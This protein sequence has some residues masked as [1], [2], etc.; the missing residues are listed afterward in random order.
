MKSILPLVLPAFLISIGLVSCEKKSTAPAESSTPETQKNYPDLASQPGQ[1]AI[2]ARCKACHSDIHHHWIK[3][4]H[5]QANRLLDPQ[6]DSLPFSNKSLN[7]GGEQWKFTTKDGKFIITTTDGDHTVDMVIGV[8]P[9]LQY[10]TKEDGGRW[11]SP[12]AAWD[13][14]K[15]EWFDVFSGDQRTAADW[16]HWTGRGMTWNTQCAWCHMTDFKKNYNISTDTY[17]SH[18]K[19]MGIG[20]TQCHGD[21]ASHADKKTGCLIDL[22]KHKK[23]ITKTPER[24]YENCATCHSRRSE[25]DDNFKFGD[26]FGDHYNLQ[27]PTQPHL[28]YP[29]GQVLD[30]DYVWTSLRISNM[31]HKGVR[32][33]DCHDP[34]T[35]KLKLPLKNNTLCLSCH[36][37]GT[38]G[39]IKGASIINLATHSHH[40]LGSK[41][42]SCV[43]CHMPHTTYM[44]RD[45][46]RDHS[47]HVPD[48]ILTKE[49]NI[50]NSCNKCHNDKDADW[51]IKWTNQWYGDKMHTP[52]RK[53]Q[54]ARTRAIAA[55]YS[56]N[57]QSLQLMLNAYATEPNPYWQASLLQILQ[58][59][60]SHP[61]VQKI[62][63]QATHHKQ[64]IV[65]AAAA[66]LLEFSLDNDKWLKPMLQDPVKEVRIAAAWAYRRN[67]AND[68]A[69][70]KEL[71]SSILFTADQPA[72]AMRM[73]QLAMDSNKLD[74]AEKWLK[75]VVQRDQSSAAAHEYYAILL[76]QMKRPKEALAQLKLAAKLAPKNAR[77]P[78]LLALTYAE[79]KQPKQ[80]GE[81]LKR[82]VKLNP[83]YDR[84]W[85]NLGLHYASQNKL[86]EAINA[87]LQAEKVNPNSPDYPY[88]RATIH[89]RLGENKLAFEACRTCLGIDR[90]YRPALQLLGRL[91]P[92]L[93]GKQ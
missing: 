19:E 76:S 56:G 6:Q 46:R 72:G 20:C 24:I 61:D 77:Y 28:Y 36:G 60:A 75:I 38:N 37:G 86:R 92:L 67:L 93:R 65:R 25:F 90:G 83:N 45:K 27:L 5:A 89:M 49:L 11:Q 1:N 70:R 73:A 3:S 35:A 79:L 82:A 42:D 44:G 69:I 74:E 41:G 40:P 22:A 15:K 9:L 2:S 17:N 53:R 26:K 16:G 34:H 68:S 58:P 32:C 43:E 80:T 13:P 62:A 12:N 23:I 78:Y 87:L 18:W 7:T 14:Y 29:D 47:F 54:R 52:E 84:A 81:Q 91:A 50:P 66:Y 59:W 30:E 63:R 85:Y 21:I 33:A 4:D 88:A 51:A 48:P 10:L 71:L 39:R 64:S 31:G 8:D 55:I 57:P